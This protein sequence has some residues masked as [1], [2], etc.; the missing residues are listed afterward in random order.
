MTK[1]NVLLFLTDGHRADALGCYGNP[2]LRTPYLDALAREGVRFTGSFSAHTVCMPS[3]ASIFTGRYPHVHGV[4]ANGIPLSRSEVTLAQVLAENGYR[5]GAFGKIH[6]EPQQAADY[7]PA[8]DREESYYGFQ[9]VRLSENK[10]GPDYLAFVDEHYPDL[11]EAVRS[12]QPVPEEAHQI[13]WITDQAMDFIGRNAGGTQPFFCFCSYHELIPPSHSPEEYT[14]RYRPEDMPE[15]KR[16]EGE[17]DAKPP[18]LKDCY[19]G[20]L[21]M[22]NEA[23]AILPYPDDET[24]R[25]YLASYYDM[26]TFLDHQF[27]RLAASLQEHS[28]WDDTIVLFTSDHGLCLNDHWQWRH[29]PFLYDQV[30]NVPMIWRVPG[31]TRPGQVDDSLVESV[32]IMPT[33]LDLAGVEVP[34]GVQGRSIRLLLAQETGAQGRDSVLGQDR[35]SPELMAR[36]VDP[37]GHEVKALRTREWKLIH[38]PGRPYGELYDLINDPDEFEN[39]WAKP[40]YAGKRQ[41]ME[42]LLLERLC[43]AED[44]L[45]QRRHMW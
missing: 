38:Y 1:P 5:T 17:L 32:D 3:R 28:L 18:Y 15:P 27:G 40:R 6:F 26:A 7:P 24:L 37:T 39:L 2:V 34:A 29:G 43:A 35:E 20:S 42:R 14:G 21:R 25:R 8:L 22:R 12:R 36:G 16:R 30:M 33:I 11:S 19:E 23:H 31:M 4:W 10:M 45:P 44:P 41:E 13:T 9:E